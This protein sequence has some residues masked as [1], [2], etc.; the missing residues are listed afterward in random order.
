MIVAARRPPLVTV[1]IPCYNQGRFLH[2][3][4]GSVARQQHPRVE[5]IV[6]NDGSTDATG[7]VARAAG[8]RV[9]DQPNRGVSAARNA[10]LQHATGDF[11]IFLDAD[12]ELLPDAISSGLA[13]FAAWPEK[14][15]VLRP[16]AL[17]DRERRPLRTNPPEI[18]RDD[19]YAELLH[20]NVAWTPGGAM[21]RCADAREAGG[22]PANV[23]HAADY[24][25]YLRFA[26]ER[27]LLYVPRPAVRYRQHGRNMSGDPV[28]MLRATLAVLD[29]EAHVLPHAYAAEWR[30]GREDWCAFYGEQI[31]DQ[32]RREWRNGRSPRR[33][34]AGAA[35][36]VRYC[37]PVVLT[38][39]IRKASRIVRGLP[40][41]GLEPDRFAQDPDEFRYD[42]EPEPHEAL[43]R[44]CDPRR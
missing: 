42:I 17:M 12:D 2:D 14:A 28:A 34:L 20:R 27:R 6:V 43:S 9:L 41:A 37:R 11:V 23:P 39:V 21:F 8:A 35:M 10:G 25:L 15:C 5:L 16:C 22:F 33:L 4:I 40:Q 31:V 3:A 32:M 24:A 26:R 19:L 7:V 36:L 18:T 38:H 44:A 1:V 30:A 29:A 13:T